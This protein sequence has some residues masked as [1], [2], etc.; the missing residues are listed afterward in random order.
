MIDGR[1]NKKLI[2]DL[3]KHLSYFFREFHKLKQKENQKE[4]QFNAS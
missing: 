3:L 1:L 2:F 4:W